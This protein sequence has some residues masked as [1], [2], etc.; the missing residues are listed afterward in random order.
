MPN[1][2]LAKELWKD[3]YGE[4]QKDIFA[5]AAFFFADASKAEGQT[6]EERFFEV[7]QGMLQLGAAWP[8][9]GA[10]RLLKH[11]MIKAGRTPQEILAVR[12]GLTPPPPA[13]GTQQQ[14]EPE[15]A[16][17]SEAS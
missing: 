17:T 4:I 6:A 11:H 12:R 15:G 10:R 3:F 16:T 1:D 8:A 9:S 14:P 5:A 13:P 2:R 7:W